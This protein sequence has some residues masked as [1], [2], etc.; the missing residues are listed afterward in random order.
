[1]QELQKKGGQLV[2]KTE[3][4]TERRI[5]ADALTRARKSARSPENLKMAPQ[6]I[7]K[8]QSAP[9]NGADLTSPLLGV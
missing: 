1:M 5:V 2:E 3:S 6:A 4:L 7:E 9:G 8:T